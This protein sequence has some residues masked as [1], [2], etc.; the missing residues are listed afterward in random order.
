MQKNT[1]KIEYIIEVQYDE[2]SAEFQKALESYRKSMY[3]N[4]DADDLVKKRSIPGP[5]KGRE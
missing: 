4:A 3:S 5:K 1:V 2:N